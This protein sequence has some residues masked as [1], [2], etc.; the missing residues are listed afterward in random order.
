MV[1]DR[2]FAVLPMK[3]QSRLV[4]HFFHSFLIHH[5]AFV[6]ID[7]FTYAALTAIPRVFIAGEMC[8]GRRSCL[9]IK[10]LQNVAGDGIA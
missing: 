10:N 2:V 7:K 4:C 3:S 8:Y 9:N 5:C 6:G 1:N